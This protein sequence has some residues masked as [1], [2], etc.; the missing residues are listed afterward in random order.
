[1]LSAVRTAGDVLQFA[2]DELKADAEVVRTAVSQN[3]VALEDASD[4]LAG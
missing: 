3:G 2:S 4:E 1:M